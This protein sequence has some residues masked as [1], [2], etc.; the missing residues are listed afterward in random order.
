ML[1][2]FESLFPSNTVLTIA[3]EAYVDEV[4]GRPNPLTA[5]DPLPS[6]ASQASQ[7]SH[8]ITILDF[9]QQDQYLRPWIS[10]PWVSHPCV[11]PT[12]D[13]PRFHLNSIVITYA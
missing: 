6:Q 13:D 12:M 2:I 11:V 10:H 7:A 3:E 9:M 4:L 8:V 5:A 1:S